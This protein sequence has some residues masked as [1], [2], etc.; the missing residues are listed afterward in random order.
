MLKRSQSVTDPL[1][2]ASDGDGFSDGL[3]VEVGSDPLNPLCTPLNC[4]VNGE[5]A[6]VLTSVLN[7]GSGGGPPS[8]EVDSVLF[9]VLNVRPAPG[10]L[11]EAES[12]IFSVVNTMPGVIAS[13]FRTTSKS[14]PA[15]ATEGEDSAHHAHR[16]GEVDMG[17][18]RACR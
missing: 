15:A 14:S 7:T 4:R 11:L 9:S 10:L 13:G 2:A 6:S 16:P 1:S 3:E 18:R 8:N 17:R 5:V 12:V